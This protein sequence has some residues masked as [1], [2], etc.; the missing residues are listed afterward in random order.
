MKRA[1][2]LFL[3]VVSCS[4]L[5]NAASAIPQYLNYQG[6][7]RDSSGNLI[8]GTKAMK[9]RVYDVA[10]GGSYKFELTSSEVVVSGGLYNVMLGSLGFAALEKG[11]RWLEVEVAGEVLSPRIELV[12]V[13]YAV[14]AASAEAAE[15]AYRAGTAATATSATSSDAVDG[16]SASSTP[17]ASTLYPLDSTGKISGVAVSAEAA[18]SAGYALFISNKNSGRIGLATSGAGTSGDH[19]IGAV[20]TGTILGG[21]ATVTIYNDNVTSTS[22]VF[23]SPRRNGSVGGANA[24]L[25]VGAISA[26]QFTVTSY[27]ESS[28]N[29]ND[30]SFDYLVI[31]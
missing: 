6:V 11:Q 5:V 16:F 22:L 31:N 14:S 19:T 29:T 27:N 8:S 9:F 18:A 23:I 4:L 20:G 12:A 10:T 17:T 21:S 13:A 3:L 2:G 28:T 30:L 26:G 15:Y 24:W 25:K 1:M 7:L